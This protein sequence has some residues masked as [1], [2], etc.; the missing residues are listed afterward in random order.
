MGIGICDHMNLQA[1][2]KYVMKHFLSKMPR[3]ITIQI[4]LE[5][6]PVWLPKLRND[7]CQVTLSA[8][9]GKYPAPK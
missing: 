1:W 3:F 2:T 6:L 9:F 4:C 5:V 7:V 8:P